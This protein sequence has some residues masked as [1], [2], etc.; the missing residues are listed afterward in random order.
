[1]LFEDYLLLFLELLSGFSAIMIGLLFLTVKS[2]N[3]IANIFLV[4]FMWSLAWIILYGMYIDSEE[5]SNMTFYENIIFDSELLIIPSLFLYII[6]TINKSFNVWYL[7]LFLPGILFNILHIEED[8]VLE[9]ISILLFPVINLPLMIIAYRFLNKHKKKVANYYSELEYKTL[10]WIKSIIITVLILHFFLL[11]GEIAEILNERL[12]DLFLFL[13][14]LTT[15]FIVYWVGYN[16][17]FQAQ[18][19][20]D[21]PSIK[22]NYQDLNQG[23]TDTPKNKI[24]NNEDFLEKFKEIETEIQTNKLFNNPNLNLRMLAAS[25]DIKEKELSKLINQYSETNFYHFINRFRVNEFKSLLQSPKAEQL[26]IL[27]LAQ[28]AG[29]SSKSTFYTAFK[30]IEGM[31]PKQ[32]E[33]SLNKYE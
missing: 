7:L 11:F 30:T 2:K 8:S 24:D 32:Y 12:G 19:F 21:I 25:L 3:Q 22:T 31:T 5:D 14:I 15:L 28:E 10:S 9:I 18:L 20:S 29:F 23:A 6:I 1:M 17:F 26:S 4:L 13:E 27:G 16:G 33:L